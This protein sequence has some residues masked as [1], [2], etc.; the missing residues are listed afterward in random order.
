MTACDCNGDGFGDLV[1]NDSGNGDAV[2]GF[3]F[4][5][6]GAGGL[7]DQARDVHPAPGVPHGDSW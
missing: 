3:R 1:I 2:T 5:R 6:G 4:F 7:E